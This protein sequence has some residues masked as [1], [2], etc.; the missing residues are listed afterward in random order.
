LRWL[1]DI[2]T[3]GPPKMRKMFSTVGISV[4]T[5]LLSLAIL[6]GSAAVVLLEHVALLAGVVDRSLVVGTRLL[7]HVI[8]HAGAWRGRSRPLSGRVNREGLVP[9]V[10][11]ALRACLTAR[12]LAFLAPLM[13]LLGLLGLAAL[14]GHVVHTLAFLAIEDGPHRLLAGSEIGGDVEQLVG[15]DQR[16]PL[17]LAHEVPAGCALEESMHDL[18]LGYAWEL[19][20]AL[21]EASY[22]VS[23]RLV[24]L[25]GARPQVPRVPGA[26]VCAL[27]VPHERA[28]QVIPVVDLI[29][30]QVL[31]PRP[32][33]VREV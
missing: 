13:L 4:T 23:E 30:R 19:N 11:V 28:N 18:G 6:S 32:S 27:E 7:Q 20:T 22:E 12:L 17:K 1:L 21:E 9:V 3:V 2:S 8:E 24:G 33:R 26:H 10:V 25:L 5:V 16:A 29:G 14:R 15:V 31:E